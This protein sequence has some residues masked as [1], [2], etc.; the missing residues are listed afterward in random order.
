M[1]TNDS[2][3]APRSCRLQS[4]KGA[5]L[6]IILAFIV[7]VTGLV[8]AFFSRALNERKI[9]DSSVNQT[10]VEVLA[11]GALNTILGDLKQEIAAGSIMNSPSVGAAV[12]MPG[13]PQTAGPALSGTG[14]L[15]GFAPN[16]LKRSASGA[17]FFSG[18]SYN[19][20]NNTVAG[21]STTTTLYTIPNRASSASTTG[22]SRNGRTISLSRW[23]KPLLLPRQTPSNTTDLTPDTTQFSAPDWILVARDGS[24]P[25]AWNPNMAWAASNATTTVIGRY[26]YVIY[27]EGG[28]LDANVAGGPTG[29]SNDTTGNRGSLALASAT[30]ILSSAQWNNLVAWRNATTA[31]TEATYKNYVYTVSATSG[32]LTVSGTVDRAF[33]SRQEL[34][35]FV[36]GTMGLPSAEDALQYLGTFSREI[37]APA[38]VPRANTATNP[39]VLTVR[40][41]NAGNVNAGGTLLKARSVHAGDLLLS[42]RFPLSRL[43]WV[44]SNGPAN[45][46]SAYDIWRAFGLVW[47]ATS[48]STNPVWV[49]VSGS[50][51]S[52]PAASSVK[53]S[54]KTLAQ[55]AAETPAREPDFFELLQA[56]ILAG[57]L[58][59]TGNDSTGTKNPASGGNTGWGGLGETFQY[60]A[61]RAYHVMQI[62]ANLIDQADVDSFPT[63][64]RFGPDSTDTYAAG[65]PRTFYGVENLPYLNRIFQPCARW[66]NPPAPLS[67]S[68]KVAN[69]A[70]PGSS[71]YRNPYVGWWTCFELWNPH[72]TDP[73]LVMSGT[74]YPTTIRV[75]AVGQLQGCQY[76]RGTA[77]VFVY[78]ATTTWTTANPAKMQLNTTSFPE[79]RLIGFSDVVA[80]T[81]SSNTCVKGSD[82]SYGSGKDFAGLYIDSV[83]APDWG[84]SAG[85]PGIKNPPVTPGPS[86]D[87]ILLSWARGNASIVNAAAG[88]VTYSLQYQDPSGNWRT[89]CQVKNNLLTLHS[90][91]YIAGSAAKIPLSYPEGWQVSYVE[92]RTDPRIDRFSAF[93]DMNGTHIPPLPPSTTGTTIRPDPSTNGIGYNGNCYPYT[94]AG[95]TWN[96]VKPVD[97]PGTTYMATLIEN[98]STSPVYY[99]DSDGVTRRG[100]GAYD[101][102]G[103]ASGQP[104]VPNNYSGAGKTNSAVNLARPVVLN[105]PLRSV[106]EMGFAARDLPWKTLDFFTKESGDAALL[107]LFSVS[108]AD[109]VAGRVNI[110]TR[111][112]EVLAA[113]LQGGVLNPLYAADSKANP[114]TMTQA[115]G[116]ATA[117]V[118]V[119]GTNPA[120]S[121][122]DL[123]TSILAPVSGETLL[124]T[125]TN[126][127]QSGDVNSKIQ[128]ESGIR[129]L[130]ETGNARTWNLLIDIIA[131]NGRYPQSLGAG[132]SLD[133]FMV[134]GEK[135][136]WMHVAID[137]Y[138]GKIVDQ[139]LEPVEE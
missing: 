26:A 107:D 31:S 36:T 99:I 116:L 105:R 12:F 118:A 111:N 48:D 54:I 40:Y 114:L 124:T 88:G 46:A 68:D 86:S 65:S 58:G 76:A 11:Q 125:S 29:L 130:A 3:L 37:N 90:A 60:D 85:N 42:R 9:S 121:R 28:L 44:G 103:N 22:T 74:S 34:I 109:M 19:F 93:R 87:P 8:V 27:D 119:T 62:G 10:K 72:Q 104:G 89:Y 15:T 43:N 47:D 127:F 57:S 81:S 79:P 63:A 94:S 59:Q 18:T 106:G 110:N 133:N 1:K 98:R 84:W 112:P 24:N 21:S 75:T 78:G 6:V 70:F 83:Y 95:T 71:N 138:T 51:S 17:A 66:I 108:D 91:G 50:G 100:D 123:V 136:Y 92:V 122:S 82:V 97:T 20:S 115:R 52:L 41:A 101:V 137:R 5:A 126:A 16:L 120:R 139:F 64:I 25:T 49:Y 80:A 135:R 96:T 67:N 56:G 4:R 55:V 73:N 134:E 14:G 33:L 32:F 30:N 53:A 128:R 77:S 35:K 13:S 113:A 102:S 7:L 117:M 132:A 39:N 61:I 131:Q 23:N 45:G 69:G 2:P 129:A 38:Y